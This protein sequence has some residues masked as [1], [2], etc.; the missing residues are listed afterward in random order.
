MTEDEALKNR[1]LK[2]KVRSLEDANKVL[3]SRCETLEELCE[4][5]LEDK[6]KYERKWREVMAVME[7]AREMVGNRE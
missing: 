4:I 7:D 5:A 2:A 6:E 3:Q 1:A